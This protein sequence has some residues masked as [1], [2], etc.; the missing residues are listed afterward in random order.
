MKNNAI[1]KVRDNLKLTRAAAFDEMKV[2]LYKGKSSQPLEAT[3]GNLIYFFFTIT[4]TI[5]IVIYYY[6]YYYRSW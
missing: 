2:E 3:P 5:I 1:Y 4:I 6:Y